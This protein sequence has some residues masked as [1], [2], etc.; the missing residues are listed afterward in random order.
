MKVE[1]EV[2]TVQQGAVVGEPQSAAAASS[3]RRSRAATTTVINADVPLANMFGYATDLR[4][5]R[6]AGTFS[7]EFARYQ[8]A[9]RDVQEEVIARAGRRDAALTALTSRRACRSVQRPGGAPTLQQ[10]VGTIAS[11][12]VCASPAPRTVPIPGAESGFVR[13]CRAGWR[14]RARL[15]GA[16]PQ[17]AQRASLCV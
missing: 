2:P 4:R 12:T 1:V 3:T 17:G 15:A 10:N 11:A 13:E 6:R 8:Q 14:G 9:P 7:M 5:R 16:E